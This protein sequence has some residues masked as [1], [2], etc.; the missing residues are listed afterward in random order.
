M[1][2]I[3][4]ITMTSVQA[5]TRR[6][7]SG[8]RASCGTSPSWSLGLSMMCSPRSTSGNRLRLKVTISRWWIRM[9]DGDMMMIWWRWLLLMVSELSMTT[10]WHLSVFRFLGLVG[11]NAG[12]RPSGEGDGHGVH[13]ASL[14]C[15]CCLGVITTITDT[16]TLMMRMTP[17]S[18]TAPSPTTTGRH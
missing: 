2:W 4:A 13:P 14:P 11:S 12:I 17:W 16:D 7:T 10:K 8:R 15:R 9:N 18:S 6:S 3:I 1:C 5:S